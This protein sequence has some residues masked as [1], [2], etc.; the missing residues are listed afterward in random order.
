MSSIYVFPGQGAQAVG[1]GYDLYQNNSDARAVF[2]EMDSALNEK[3]SDIIFNG[4]IETLTLTANVQPAILATSIAM[5]RAGNY[6]KPDFMAGHSL[7]EYT[8]LCAAG[9][10]SLTDAIKLVRLRGESMQNAV[11]A[12]Q[13]AM[14]VI[15]GIEHDTLKSVCEKAEQETNSICDIANDNCPGQIVISGANAAIERAMELSKE[16]GAKRAMKL[17]LSVPPHSRLMQPVVDIMKK[18]LDNTEIKTPIVPII[19]NKTCQPM[20]DVNEIKDALLYQ[21]THGVRWRES[22]LS[23]VNLGID[24]LTEIGPGNALIGMVNRTT[25]KINAHK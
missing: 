13:G 5:F 22:V 14:A 24:D 19:S 20:T 23:M 2:D 9:A 18:A 21:I 10:L 25:D 6:P 1:M 17:A 3:L 8:A 11:P 16:S 7:G 12:G 15:L 4:P